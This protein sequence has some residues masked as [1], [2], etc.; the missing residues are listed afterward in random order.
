MSINEKLA[1]LGITLPQAPE[2]GGVYTPVKEF[3]ASMAYV[4]GCGP[5]IRET[6]FAGKLGQ[7]VSFEE[8]QR[9]AENCV[10]NILAILQRDLGSLDVIARMAKM[11]VFVASDNDFYQQPQVANAAT[12]LL[13][14]I[15]GEEV[16]C[17]S[18]SAVGANVLPGNIPVEIELL[19]EL[20][21]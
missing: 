15:F 13:V 1:S 6:S 5:N 2:R 11:T 16:G 8:G 21:K 10:L 14:N 4:S 19:L 12:S 9:A 18:R 7:E 3:G 20:K 17:P